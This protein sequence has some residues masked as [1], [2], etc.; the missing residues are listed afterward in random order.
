M[1]ARSRL[2]VPAA[3][4]LG[5]LGVLAGCG[6]HDGG[7]TRCEDFALMSEGDRQDVVR[8]LLTEDGGAEPSDG[9]VS[10]TVTAASYHCLA[11]EAADDLVRDVLG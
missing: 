2:P 1:S 9:T 6:G 4:L 8:A 3:L 5:V 11:P 7:D 10:L